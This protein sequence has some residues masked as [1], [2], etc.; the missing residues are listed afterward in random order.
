[1]AFF[2]AVVSHA[3]S[4]Y[5]LN[6]MGVCDN[7][8]IIAMP[9]LCRSH[10]DSDKLKL[11]SQLTGQPAVFQ[12]DILLNDRTVEYLN[13]LSEHSSSPPKGE[14]GEGGSSDE[15]QLLQM[16]HPQ[17]QKRKT[18]ASVRAEMFKWPNATVIFRF[19]DNYCEL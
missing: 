17:W 12:G 7:G 16:M 11:Q 10:F 13:S 5:P 18:R 8:V 1:M 3:A 2:S 15:A 19:D 9:S 14:E 6:R 4:C